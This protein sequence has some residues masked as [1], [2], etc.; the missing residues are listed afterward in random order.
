MKAS[1]LLVLA[2]AAACLYGGSTVAQDPKLTIRSVQGEFDLSWPATAT[3]WVLEHAKH[4]QPPIP[5]IRVTPESYV[6]NGGTRSARVAALES[7]RFYRLRNAGPPVPGLAGLWELDEGAGSL[8]NEGSGG[9]PAM[10]LSNASWI[11]GRIGPGALR[12]NGGPANG[13]G[14][15]AWVSNANYSVLPSA[16]Q[17][18][19]VSLW[20]NPEGIT[21]GWRGI[22][23]NAANG[24]NGWHVLSHTPGLGTNLLVFASPGGS[25]SVTGRTLLLPGQWHQLTVTHDGA[26]GSL[27]LDSVLLA[28]GGGTLATH[29]GPIYFGGG[30]GNYDSFWGGIDDIRVYTN[31][32]ASEQISLNGHWR[33]DEANDS[34]CSDASIQGHHAMLMNPA[35]RV[36]GRTGLA[37]DLNQTSVTI[38][39]DYRRVLPP[40]G[41]AFSIGFWLRP[42]VLPVGQSALMSCGE[43]SNNGWQLSANVDFSGW[44]RLHLSS[45]N[46]GGTMNLWTPIMLTNGMWTRVDVTY[47]GGVASVFAN[48]RMVESRPGAIRGSRSPLV[49]GAPPNATRFQGVIDDL[50]IHSV[51]RPESDIGPIAK[52][53]WETAFLQTNTTLVLQGAGPPDKTLTYSIVNPPTHGTL[54]HIAGSPIVT[55]QA[56][57][58]KGPDTFAYT[59]SDGEFTSP[60]AI[61][62]VSVVQ[63]HW[64]SP[65]GGTTL[66]LDGSSPARAWVAGPATALDEIWRTNSYYDCFHYA[67]GEYQTRGWKHETRISARPGCKH[68]GSGSSGPDR[69]TL[70]LVDNLEAWTEGVIFGGGVTDGFEVH[71]LV[72]DCNADNLP[73][74]TIGEPVWLNVPLLNT[75]AVSSVTLRWSAGVLGRAAQFS[76][77]T[78]TS[79]TE[80]YTCTTY[81]S[82]GQVDV[83]NPGIPATELLVRLERRAPGVG[84]YGLSEVEVAGNSVSLARATLP[85]G[86]P[87]RL[88]VEHGIGEAVDGDSRSWWTSGPESQVEISLP[89]APGTTISQL[90]VRWNCMIVGGVGRLG[91]AASYVIRA[92]NESTGQYFDVPFFRSAR[93]A[94]GW[95]TSSFSP[96]VTDQ[97]VLLLTE[98]EPLV[99][100]YSL[101][102][103]SL[104]NGPAGVKLRIPTAMSDVNWGGVNHRAHRAFDG[105][106]ATQW[107]SGTQGMVGAVDI[108]GSNL[109]FTRLK[110]VGFGTKAGRECFV[111]FFFTQASLPTPLRL[112]NILIEDCLVTE[113]ATNNT[114]GLSVLALAATPP[115]SLTNA[116]IRR[117][118][119]KGVRPYFGYSHAFGAAQLEDCLVEDCEK[120]V[121]FEPNAKTVDDLG[122]ILIRR[123]RFINVNFGLHMLSQAA[124]E[125]DSITF[126]DNEVV[127][128]GGGGAGFSVCDTCNLGPSGTVTNITLLNNIIRYP[129]WAPR[130]AGF[131]G[132]LPYTN[133][134]HA[135]IGNNVVALGT[136]YEFRIRDC[137]A[138]LIPSPDPVE[139]CTYADPTP[140]PPPSTPP[141][142]NLLLPGYQRAW[143]NNR[144]LSGS[145]LPVRFRNYGVDAMASEQQWTD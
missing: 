14:S 129:D 83:V 114:D 20:F 119:V 95:E 118:T 69:T 60:P 131:E 137:P 54:N 44:A 68:I 22:M 27:Y 123:N 65:S 8:A 36:P 53:M 115:H 106:N 78:R 128:S 140:P 48:G 116:I 136:A 100:Y 105:T 87:S 110:I 77:C 103:V 132:G 23:G 97:L 26:A 51:A 63:P 86:A 138:G 89:V 85:G 91:A 38:R 25:L 43:G 139:D 11:S 52:T 111:M 47:N 134:R 127:L 16:G 94:D 10:S 92:R 71:N 143:F 121:Y 32:L 109:K 33:F 113:P 58:Q 81:N 55:Y 4:L 98:K 112:G 28:R 80:N 104:Q 76:V 142:V 24:N 125:F 62:T 61:V 124:A 41:G 17:A 108:L 30:V 13:I 74:Y 72:L 64:L 141:C 144:N 37:V 99:N 66:P 84:F 21:P 79:P 35:A 93:D 45:T 1:R 7:R 50:K 31:T 126:T 19:S 107:A 88:D 120:A 46:N 57:N 6:N 101:K 96:I 12:F 122:H 5:W 29:D 130:P 49:I 117:C 18:F 56:G 40:S 145:L 42:D 75:S 39:N 34:F 73:K 67:P 102:E 90:T 2:I 9:A 70:K 135:I 3:N 133:M 82:T 59:V 15:R